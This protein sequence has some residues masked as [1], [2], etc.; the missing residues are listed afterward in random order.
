M[1]K[2]TVYFKC[3]PQFIPNVT[4]IVGFKRVSLGRVF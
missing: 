4:D 1:S 3:I 2:T